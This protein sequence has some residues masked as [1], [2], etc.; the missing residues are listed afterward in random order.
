VAGA[1]ALYKASNPGATP[2]QVQAALQNAGGIDWNHSDDGDS[3]KE[4]LLNVSSF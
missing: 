4:P 2:A 3:T 1:A